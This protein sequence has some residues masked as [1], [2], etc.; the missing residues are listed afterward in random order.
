MFVTLHQLVQKRIGKKKMLMHPKKEKVT[1][2][3]LWIKF[4]END[5]ETVHKAL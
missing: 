4:Q 2:D 1:F 5:P 3:T